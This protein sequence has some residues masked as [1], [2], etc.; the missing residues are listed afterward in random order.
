[1]NRNTTKGAKTLS[2]Y[3]Q[4]LLEKHFPVAE[5][6]WIA[7]KAAANKVRSAARRHQAK[8]GGLVPVG[9][10]DV[11]VEDVDASVPVFKRKAPEVLLRRISTLRI[12]LTS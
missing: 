1:M 3:E 11:D 2:P 6:K 7:A 4:H 10:S 5:N 9:E 8:Q 12:F